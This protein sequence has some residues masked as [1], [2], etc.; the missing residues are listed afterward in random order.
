MFMSSGQF[1]M[2]TKMFVNVCSHTH[3]QRLFNSQKGKTLQKEGKSTMLVHY[4]V[5]IENLCV[6]SNEQYMYII[7]Y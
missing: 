1:Q 5:N 4:P 2:I 6:I 7:V 3:R